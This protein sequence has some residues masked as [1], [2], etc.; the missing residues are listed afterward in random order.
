MKNT[1]NNTAEVKRKIADA[2]IKNVVKP[3]AKG[4]K[5]TGKIYKNIY[6]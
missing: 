2:I 6:K 1:K 4:E 5:P 3:M